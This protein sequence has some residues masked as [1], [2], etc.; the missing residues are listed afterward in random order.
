[1]FALPVSPSVEPSNVRFGLSVKVLP[2]PTITTRLS[3]SVGI[4]MLDAVIIPDTTLLDPAPATIGPLNCVAVI[5]PDAFIFLIFL[6]SP[7][8]IKSDDDKDTFPVRP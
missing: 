3:V 4:L 8:V 2:D 1:M 6:I 5:I 7:I